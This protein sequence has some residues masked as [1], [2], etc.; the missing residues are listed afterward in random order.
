[1]DSCGGG[2]NV[3]RHV[4][5]VASSRAITRGCVRPVTVCHDTRAAVTFLY[6][7]VVQKVQ[8]R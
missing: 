2:G 8:A 5:T 7:V 6:V 3:C 4:R 1:M